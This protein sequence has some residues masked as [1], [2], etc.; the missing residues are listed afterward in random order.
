[1]KGLIGKKIG[2]TTV[3]AEDGT[4]VPVTVVEATP[5]LVFGHRTQERDGYT[6]LQ[7]GFDELEE[8]KADR[9]ETK[10]YLGQFKKKG[11]KPH[12][13]IKEFRVEAN[14]LNDFAVGSQVTVALFK[15]GDRV[16][17]VGT[18]RGMGF[19]GVV[20]R[21]HMK[22]QARNAASAHEVHRHMG[23]VGMRKTPG[24]V[25]K[26]KRMPGH[27]GTERCTVQNLTVVDVVPES[28]LLLISGS[29]PG[30]DKSVVMV[31]PAVK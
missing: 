25:F 3:F 16:D 2:M 24:R 11:Q 6:A 23:A 1:M 7:L 17:V 27:M 28:N 13:M 15:K 21:H 18:S 10:P 5:N 31:K 20:K 14:E 4:A 29:V 22:G 26:G 30:Y 19:A 9:R 12:R 8:K